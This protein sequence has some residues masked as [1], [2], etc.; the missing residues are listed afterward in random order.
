MSIDQMR[1]E[2]TKARPGPLW[3]HRVLCMPEN[4]VVAVYYSFLRRGEFN[5]KP[6]KVKQ[7]PVQLS[8]F[9]FMEG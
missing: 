8:I 5:K 6:V 9:D 1:A 4:Q 2:L 7:E 3:Q